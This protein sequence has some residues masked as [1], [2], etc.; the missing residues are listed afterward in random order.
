MEARLAE[1]TGRP[2]PEPTD[3]HRH[4]ERRFCLD[5]VSARTSRR[6]RQRD[7]QLQPR[8]Q[9]LESWRAAQLTHGR[10]LP[11]G[12]PCLVG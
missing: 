6:S 11:E 7:K 9:G 3:E 12:L 4:R 1:A 8:V 2:L 10:K 5:P